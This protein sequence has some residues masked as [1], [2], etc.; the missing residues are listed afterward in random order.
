MWSYCSAHY[1]M[2]FGLSRRV[3]IANRKQRRPMRLRFTAADRCAR[4]F[5]RMPRGESIGRNSVQL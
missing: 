1:A 3:P 2:P 5:S 4:A